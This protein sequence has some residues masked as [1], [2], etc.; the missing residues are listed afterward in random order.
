MSV[1]YKPAGHPD[2]SVYMMAAEAGA[3]IAFA[4]AVFDGEVLMKMTRPDGSIM[5]A[6][7]RIGDSVIMLSQGMG[8]YPP[9]PV[10]CTSMFRT[11]MPP[12]ARP[13]STAAKA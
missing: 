9:F 12:T 2:V 6:E 11:W 1:S 4:E 13:W 5:H 3:V 8:G 10:W 7:L